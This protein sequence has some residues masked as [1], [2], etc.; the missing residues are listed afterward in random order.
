MLTGKYGIPLAFLLLGTSLPA[1][2]LP[3]AGVQLQQI[4]PPPMPPQSQPEMRIV[5]LASGAAAPADQARFPVQSIR[6][7][8]ASLFPDEALVAATGFEPGAGQSLATLQDMAARIAEYY[9]DHG[10]ALVDAYLP[11]QEIRD[12]VVTIAVTEARYGR[13]DV[14]NGSKLSGKLVGAQIDGLASG[15]P[16]AL[17]PLESRLLALSD[18]PGIRVSSTLSPGAAAG[19][20]DLLIDISP[21]PA[22]NASIDADNAGNRY[23]GAYRAGA[24]LQINNPLGI[25]D[26]VSL[27]ML[28]S[29]SGLIYGRAAYEWQAGRAR[30][31]AGYSQLAY[32]LGREFAS[33][34][35]NGRAGVASLYGS[36]PLVRSRQARLQAQLAL[37][38]KTYR[39]R[40]DAI[41][42]ASDRNTWSLAA[43]LAGERSDRFAGGGVSSG[44][45][46]VATGAVD[47]RTPEARL[48]DARTAGS[49]GG[50]R[51]FN[52]QA[53]RLQNATRDLSFYAA[54]ALQAAS[55]NLSIGEK[56]A[57]GGVNAVRA[58]P[59]GEAY[60][61]QGMLL[62]LEA[63]Y[64][65][66][67]GWGYLPGQVQLIAFVDSGRAWRDKSPWTS[68]AQV[69]T[70]SGA[71]LGI[72]IHDSGNYLVKLYYAHRLGA[73]RVIS[74]PDS[75]QRVWLQAV[76]FF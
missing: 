4:G 26:I 39:D 23:S 27:R 17:G 22:V 63:R 67:S 68:G 10:Y 58:Y 29:G 2:D 49:N 3:G 56:M 60:A 73:A 1:A 14:R 59:D 75:S 12:G 66:K 35:A 28:T 53:A 11:P 71:G 16:V 32:R 69:R 70:L 21:G 64:R 55:K 76:K 46:S 13:I 43:G 40:A 6:I 36:Y 19:A 61:D 51:K 74:E 15:D 20:S 24:S 18:L 52:L 48:T 31:G 57:L 30:L 9:R 34:D 65:L 38:Y 37:E 72:A 45:F 44:A 25:G 50:Y 47:I 5:P 54:L 62:T 8:G 7:E 41:P 42:A 33:L